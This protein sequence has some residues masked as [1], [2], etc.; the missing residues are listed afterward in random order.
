ATA[1]HRS[2]K[3][4]SGNT[5]SNCC[6]GGTR[7]GLVHTAS[8]HL[9]TAGRSDDH[10]LSSWSCC[11]KVPGANRRLMGKGFVDSTGP[12]SIRAG[13]HCKHVSRLDS[14]NLP[15]RKRAEGIRRGSASSRDDDGHWIVG[16]LPDELDDASLAASICRE[17]WAGFT[18]PAESRSRSVVSISGNARLG[19][20]KKGERSRC[21]P[22]G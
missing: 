2:G 3:L 7:T 1:R 15:R 10:Y 14:P 12:P 17:T 5:G 11:S 8:R 21:H 22:T 19:L 4:V 20:C 16:G 18:G 13:P 6:D 9:V